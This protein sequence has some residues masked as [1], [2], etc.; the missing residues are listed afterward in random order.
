MAN[1]ITLNLNADSDQDFLALF[2][3]YSGGLGAKLID[4]STSE[5]NNQVI[6]QLKPILVERFGQQNFEQ[7]EKQAIGLL[8]GQ[9]GQEMVQKANELKLTF[10]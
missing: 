10:E 4:N 5:V 8:E 7:M 1:T 6:D 2:G 3:L 9:F